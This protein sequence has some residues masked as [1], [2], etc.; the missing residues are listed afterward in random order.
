MMFGLS[1]R[2]YVNEHGENVLGWESLLSCNVFYRDIRPTQKCWNGSTWVDGSIDSPDSKYKLFTNWK[3]APGKFK[4]VFNATLIQLASS[5]R[6]SDRSRRHHQVW[7]LSN[8]SPILSILSW[9]FGALYHRFNHDS[10]GKHT[11]QRTIAAVPRP[12]LWLPP[13][14]SSTLL[15][16]LDHMLQLWRTLPSGRSRW[17]Q[18]VMKCTWYQSRM[19]F[20][21][22]GMPWC[23]EIKRHLKHPDWLALILGPKSLV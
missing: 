5:R 12:R 9:I 23:L 3:S 7:K 22:T 16:T 21:W 18:C 15:T 8:Q 20:F 11:I 1:C 2:V 6:P 13:M 10:D 19:R 4:N 14:M 17:N